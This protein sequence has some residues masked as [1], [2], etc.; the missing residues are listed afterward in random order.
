M[1]YKKE[2]EKRI[3]NSTELFNNHIL[4]RERERDIKTYT[5]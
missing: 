1:P 2:K 5:I 3:S 4:E